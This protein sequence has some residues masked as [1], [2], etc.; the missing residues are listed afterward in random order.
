MAAALSAFPSASS[1]LIGEPVS[2]ALSFG[3]I[4]TV[5]GKLQHILVAAEKL[6]LFAR[7]GVISDSWM[8]TGTWF[9]FAAHTTGTETK[10]PF[11]NTMEGLSSLMI[12]FASPKPFST[13]NGSVKFCREKYLRSFPVAI[14]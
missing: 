13:L 10:P 3:S 12:R 8:M 4:L 6:S 9:F 1:A 2:T 5:S 7:P 14:P 11:E